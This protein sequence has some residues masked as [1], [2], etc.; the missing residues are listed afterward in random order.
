[1]SLAWSRSLA[2][3]YSDASAAFIAPLI[4][5]QVLRTHLPM[6]ASI[7]SLLLIIYSV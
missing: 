7:G 4:W 2:S 3:S 1:M 5:F 6:A